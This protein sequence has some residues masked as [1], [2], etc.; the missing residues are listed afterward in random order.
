MQ[1]SSGAGWKTSAPAYDL[2]VPAHITSAM[3][4]EQ[5][6]SSV[7]VMSALPPKADVRPCGWDVR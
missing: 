4:H 2:R 7:R 1:A 3:G 6:L 5:T